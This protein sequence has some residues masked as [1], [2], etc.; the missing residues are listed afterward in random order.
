MMELFDSHCHVDEPKFD[1]DR[2]E[3]LLRMRERG[4]TRLVLGQARDG[5]SAFVTGLMRALPRVAL[6]IEPT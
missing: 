6:I 2:D 5:S 4:V 3:A 1:S